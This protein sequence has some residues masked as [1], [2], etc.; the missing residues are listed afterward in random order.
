MLKSKKALISSLAALAVIGLVSL[1]IA[2]SSSGAS[3]L[4]R[5]GS[6]KPLAPQPISPQ[7][8]QTF[9][10]SDIELRWEW[11][12][13]LADNQAFAVHLWYEG[14]SP[15]EAWTQETS[16]DAQEL[17]DSYSRD[18][19]NFYWQV[20]V[21]NYSQEKGFEGMSSEWSAVQTLS[22]VRRFT[23]TPY[24]ASQQSDLARYI[25]SLEL[26]SY[27][28][29]IDYTRTFIN[30]NSTGGDQQ[31]DDPDRRKAIDMMF[32]YFQ[33][34]G[35]IPQ[36]LCD[37]R[38]TAMLTLLQ[39]LGVE[40]RLIFLYA[41]GGAGIGQH[42]VLEVFNPDTQ[43]WEIHDPSEDLYFVDTDAHSRASIERLV[44]GPL[45][46]IVGCDSAGCSM[47]RAAKSKDLF[48]AFRYG[49]GDTFWV[50]PDRF[51]VSKRFPDND[52]ANLA[53]YLTGNPRDFT[54][55]FDSWADN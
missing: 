45:D 7:D 34:R 46:S 17:I 25:A 52:G 49:H 18:L 19:G 53:E 36:L 26:S 41:D 38:S 3:L 33:G 21:V 55:R 11:S 1:G 4:A 13:G 37:G 2:L 50:N 20:A 15:I 32:E 40:S 28:E 39:E 14:E 8:G 42:T 27:T 44:F 5:G 29:V 43:Q 35:E 24:P 16:F 47:E 48:D 6:G 23:P 31:R 12:P 22:R 30:T 9:I 10:E 51:D 54:F